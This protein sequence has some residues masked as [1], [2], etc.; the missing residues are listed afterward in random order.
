MEP[1]DC[2]RFRLPPVLR[3]NRAEVGHYFLAIATGTTC[4]RFSSSRALTLCASAG[5]EMKVAGYEAESALREAFFGNFG[6]ARNDAKEAS[7]LPG[8]PDVLGGPGNG[9]LR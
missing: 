8:G 1:F 7:K 9:V 3:H 6:E 5:S 2:E 4:V